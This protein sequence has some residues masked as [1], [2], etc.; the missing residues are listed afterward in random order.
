MIDE[1]T[2]TVYYLM[3][4]YNLVYRLFTFHFIQ[5]FI[6]TNTK[7]FSIKMFDLFKDIQFL[8]SEKLK[9]W[10]VCFVIL[11]QSIQFLLSRNLKANFF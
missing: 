4:I 5:S 1:Y 11:H 10:T 7:T 3:N 9:F 8:L 2:Y 6:F